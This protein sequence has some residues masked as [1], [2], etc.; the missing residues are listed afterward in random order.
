MTNSYRFF[1]QNKLV[2]KERLCDEGT[3]FFFCKILVYVFIYN[4]N[5]TC[6]FYM[7]VKFGRLSLREERRLR[8]LEKNMLSRIF[9]SKRKK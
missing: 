1:F 4:C 6:C 8:V 9:E 3:N 7:G 5:F 2:V